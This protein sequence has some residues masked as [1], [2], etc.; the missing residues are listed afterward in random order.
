MGI[1]PLWFQIAKKKLPLIFLL[2][3]GLSLP[4]GARNAFA[5]DGKWVGYIT[6]NPSPLDTIYQFELDLQTDGERI[7]GHTM[8]AFTSRPEYYGVIRFEGLVSGNT[9]VFD[10]LELM[11]QL[12]LEYAYWCLKR[13]SLVA[14]FYGDRAILSGS[15]T[16]DECS[17]S[18]GEVYLE[19]MMS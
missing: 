8:I 15:W 1:F 10:E 3:F 19:R 7:F 13:I 11:D 18:T 17:F 14:N 12:M 5:L 4:L 6:Q 16:S 9:L 2:L